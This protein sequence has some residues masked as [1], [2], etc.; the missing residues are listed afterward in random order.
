MKKF[1]K[2]KEV[3]EKSKR[4]VRNLGL[5]GLVAGSLFFSRTSQA[6]SINGKIFDAW[7]GQT[8]DG[9]H[10]EEIINDGSSGTATCDVPYFGI[11][12]YWAVDSNA[13]SP[14]PIPG[15]SDTS[16]ISASLTVGPKTYTT[17]AR[18]IYDNS[19]IIF[20]TTFL[21]D[22][23]KNVIAH[24]FGIWNITDTSNVSDTL[25]AEGWL[26]KNPNQKIPFWNYRKQNSEVDTSDIRS[27]VYINA[28]EQDSIWNQG[29]L[30]TIRLY[31][32]DGWESDTSFPIDTLKH[33]SATMLD[34]IVFPERKIVTDTKPP[35]KPTTLLANSSSPS[36]WT[37]SPNFT[38]SWTNPSDPDLKTA[39]Y[40]IGVPATD[41]DTTESWNPTSPQ[42]VNVTS[43]GINPLYLW[44][45]DSSDNTSKD[46]SAVVD[47]R[48]D[49]TPP[50]GSVA[51]SP[52]TSETEDFTVNWSS[53]NDAHSGIESYQV[54]VKEDT[55]SWT[56]WISDTTSTSATFNG[57][58]NKTYYFESAARDSA[59]NLEAFTSMPECST[60]VDTTTPDMTP[61]NISDVTEWSETDSTGPY[62][63]QYVRSD[64]SGISGDSLTYRVNQGTSKT[65]PADSVKG[66]TAYCTIDTTTVAEDSVHYRVK[67]ID[68]SANANVAYWPSQDGWHSFKVKGI[69]IEEPEINKEEFKAWIA[70]SKLHVEGADRFGVHDIAGR[71]IKSYEN[72]SSTTGVYDFN[73]PSG[74]YFV[75][76]EEG[77]DKGKTEK[78]IVVK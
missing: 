32:D 5:T 52:D 16:K 48:Y 27:Q 56:D 42:S 7:N 59:G 70:G 6:G 1:E 41:W 74:I 14:P 76:S 44:L 54:K 15:T 17:H 72:E 33:G 34:S 77:K 55:G 29:D 13:H 46:S 60:K 12:G 49:A 22:P 68:G 19:N 38:I 66:D 62:A 53:G 75:R 61:P 57:Q 26:N 50:S 73:V 18:R 25:K 43:E 78:V 35:G 37:N 31:S 4:V 23:D 3:W 71:N 40:K 45:A 30:V 20:P 2:V 24:A 21:D 51:S 47:I 63:V 28:E 58:N 69:G 11:K 10:V 64:E 9:T 65:V 67:T 39:L 36:P 8:S